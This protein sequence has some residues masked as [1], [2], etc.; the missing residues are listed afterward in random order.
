MPLI[1]KVY[2]MTTESIDFLSL[3]HDI[4]A[5][6]KEVGAPSGV[7]HVVV[8]KSGAGVLVFENL[9]EV[10]EAVI[11]QLESWGQEGDVQDRLRRTVALAPRIQSAL[12]P[13][14]FVCPFAEQNLVLAPY[15]EILLVD[16]EQ[17][18]QRREVIVAILPEIEA[19]TE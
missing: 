1:K 2:V 9:P 6:I 17:R 11:A 18:A 4:T 15:E 19:Q 7:V 14:S 8:P 16:C 13:R 10:R 5:A 12:L 3:N